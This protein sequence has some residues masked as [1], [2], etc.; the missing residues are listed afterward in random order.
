MTSREL[1]RFLRALRGLNVIGGEVTENIDN[2]FQIEFYF[3]I[4]LPPELVILL[5]M[6]FM[7]PLWRQIWFEGTHC[8]ALLAWLP[9]SD[10]G[11]YKALDV[12][13]NIVLSRCV[14]SL[15]TTITPTCPLRSVSIT[16]MKSY[17]FT[18]N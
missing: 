3:N 1:F 18:V 8:Y 2:K 5:K 9:I 14:S 11:V 10:I 12:F 6:I 4:L 13:L 7:R 17:V 15:Q 16:C